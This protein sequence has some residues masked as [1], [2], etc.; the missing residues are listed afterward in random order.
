[1]S[2]HFILLIIYWNLLCLISTSFEVCC[3]KSDRSFLL[4]STFH[5]TGRTKAFIKVPCHVRFKEK[6]FKG[7]ER[8]DI[9]TC[10][11]FEGRGSITLTRVSWYPLLLTGFFLFFYFKYSIDYSTLKSFNNIMNVGH[12]QKLQACHG[13][14]HGNMWLT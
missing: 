12:N 10:L 13:H 3:R 11:V 5:S 6:C 14:G 9:F 7:S 1:V 2:I 4:P 8:G